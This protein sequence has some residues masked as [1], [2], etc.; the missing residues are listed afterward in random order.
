MLDSAQA[1][2]PVRGARAL[3]FERLV[4]N[5][6]ASPSEGKA[7]RVLDL[8][9]L[10]QS[11]RRELTRLLNTRSPRPEAFENGEPLTVL[12]YGIPDFSH[13]SA[14]SADDRRRF[15]ETLSRAIAAFEP[16]LRQV[17]VTLE[18]SPA[19]PTRLTGF[20]DAILE[21]GTVKEPISFPLSVGGSS[22][23]AAV[24]LSD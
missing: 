8:P 9:A 11:V 21:V 24:L 3:L 1:P 6:P 20:V 23:G 17:K 2:K 10:R 15:A 12:E 4:D 5:E 18:P 22:A 14:A 19:D 13:R 16:R 7:V